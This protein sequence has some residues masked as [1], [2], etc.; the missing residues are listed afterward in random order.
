MGT[1]QASVARFY[2]IIAIA[3]LLTAC[4]PTGQATTQPRQTI[5]IG[6]V[7]MFSG[8]FASYGEWVRE[9]A[10]LGKAEAEKRWNIDIKLVYEDSGCTARELITALAKLQSENIQLIT[11]FPCAPDVG[12]AW[13]AENNMLMVQGGDNLGKLSDN[14]YSTRYNTQ[15]AM[16]T[17]A[18]FAYD[19]QGA[20]RTGIIYFE[21]IWG[22]TSKNA[23]AEQFASLGGTIV[24]EESIN[25][26]Q[27]FRTQ[28]L[29]FKHADADSV[30]MIYSNGAHFVNQ[31]AELEMNVTK[32]VDSQ[33][34]SDQS[35]AIGGKNLEGIYY[36]R[37]N[38][39]AH[40]FEETYKRTYGKI[41]DIAAVGTYDSVLVAVQAAVQCENKD[42][43]CLRGAI[44][45]TQG[46]PGAGGALTFAED[47]W[48]FVEPSFMIKTYRD[49]RYQQYS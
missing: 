29:K 32:L 33:F 23:Y 17:L 27:D 16:A 22:E 14:W 26:G 19:E 47:T 35:I 45:T 20:R 40:T 28:L 21:G 18:Q 13:V 44:Q 24:G 3:L 10:E 37:P 7:G 5:T 41:P 15:D 2:T 30:L 46:L 34:E 6:V 43:H 25:G 12:A 49:G 4:T 1:T 39:T 9:G 8:E 42:V 38:T 36:V 31:L 11:G 48:S